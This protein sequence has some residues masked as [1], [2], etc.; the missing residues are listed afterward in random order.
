MEQEFVFVELN[1]ND[2]VASKF[3]SVNYINDQEVD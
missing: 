1:A 3:I 2:L